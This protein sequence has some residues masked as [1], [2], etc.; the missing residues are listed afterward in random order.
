MFLSL[1]LCLVLLFV[2][3]VKLS[4]HFDMVSEL[5]MKISHHVREQEVQLF[6][7]SVSRSALILVFDCGSSLCFQVVSVASSMI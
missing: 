4:Y 6:S 2:I 1:F 7:S 5:F 3:H